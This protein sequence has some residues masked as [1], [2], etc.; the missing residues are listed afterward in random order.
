MLRGFSSLRVC[1]LEDTLHP[2]HPAALSPEVRPPCWQSHSPKQQGTSSQVHPELQKQNDQVNDLSGRG[3]AFCLSCFLVSVPAWQ[4]GAESAARPEGGF[5]VPPAHSLQRQGRGGRNRSLCHN[6]W[7][8]WHLLF[9]NRANTR[10]D[11]SELTRFRETII[12]I[13]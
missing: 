3:G 5:G 11:F 2:V 8:S 1:S 6:S 13:G 7:L 4:P 10:H 12:L 9:T